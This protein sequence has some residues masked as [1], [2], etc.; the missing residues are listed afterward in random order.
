M[1]IQVEPFCSCSLHDIVFISVIY[2]I[3]FWHITLNVYFLLANVPVQTGKV[4]SLKECLYCDVYLPAVGRI[5]I[6]ILCF[7]FH[8]EF[9]WKFPK[10]APLSNTCEEPVNAV[11]AC[12]L[13][14]MID[15][16]FH[17]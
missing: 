11:S 14:K 16:S 13:I 15:V 8:G 6:D 10:F 3:V 12:V 17:T 1:T 2:I 5:N 4:F 7:V 9:L